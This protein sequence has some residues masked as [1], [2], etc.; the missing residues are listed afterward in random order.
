MEWLIGHCEKC[1]L[2]LDEVAAREDEEG[3]QQDF[4][5]RLR[6]HPVSRTTTARADCEVLCSRRLA[7]CVVR[8]AG[9]SGS[10]FIGCAGRELLQKPCRVNG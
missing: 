4:R 8:T 10:R 2:Q 1:L 6:H 3:Q 9:S 7:V 5:L